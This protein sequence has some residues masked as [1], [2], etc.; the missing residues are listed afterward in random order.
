MFFLVLEKLGLK[1]SGEPAAKSADGESAQQGG[2]APPS[3]P[4]GEAGRE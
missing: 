4:A 3:A 2:D 1:L